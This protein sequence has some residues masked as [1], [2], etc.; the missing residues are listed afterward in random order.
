MDSSGRSGLRIEVLNQPNL[1]LV[2]SLTSLGRICGMLLTWII[3]LLPTTSKEMLM[4]SK[5]GSSWMQRW[6]S[7]WSGRFLTACSITSCGV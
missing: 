7:C 5:D 3:Q 4:H 6:S 2:W 1:G